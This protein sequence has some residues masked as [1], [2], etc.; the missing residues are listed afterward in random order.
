MQ[1]FADNLGISYVEGRRVRAPNSFMIKYKG[2]DILESARLQYPNLKFIPG[3]AIM[4]STPQIFVEGTY[5][6]D[7]NLTP[8]EPVKITYKGQE[9]FHT[10]P[11][12]KIGINDEIDLFNHCSDF[13]QP[14]L[15][16][17]DDEL[18]D[19]MKS[20]EPEQVTDNI[21]RIDV[22]Y[23]LSIFI[24]TDLSLDDCYFHGPIHHRF[25]LDE[26]YKEIGFDF[27]NDSKSYSF[28]VN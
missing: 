16:A 13:E 17:P 23:G 6:L 8:I 14:K 26:E 28:A 25:E 15:W 3:D 27:L 22:S 9:Y 20:I 7:K 11:K 10:F 1:A 24:T 19:L 4:T 2:G 18:L 21:L 5:I 12:L